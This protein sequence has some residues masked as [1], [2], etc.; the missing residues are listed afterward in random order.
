MARRVLLAAR[1]SGEAQRLQELLDHAGYEVEVTNSGRAAMKQARATPPDLLIAFPNLS[2]LSPGELFQTLRN[3]QNGRP[4]ALLAVTPAPDSSA[5]IQALSS[6]ADWFLQLPSTPDHI[7]SVVQEVVDNYEQNRQRLAGDR[8]QVMDT[9]L[10]TAQTLDQ[11]R[12][13]LDAARRELDEARRQISAQESLIE[14]R[15][16]ERTRNLE[17]IIQEL[18]GAQEQS[19]L[20]AREFRAL[21]DAEKQ[22][23]VD[24][25]QAVED[26]QLAQR[27]SLVYARDLHG[28]FEAER[29]RAEELRAA[30]VELEGSY[31]AT[32]EALST[33]LD[34][35]DKETEGHSRRVTAYTLAVARALGLMDEELVHV[36]RGAYLHDVGKIGIPDSIL[37]KPAKLT[38]EE[39]AVMKR[40]PEMGFQ[41]VGGIKFLT[42]AAPIVLHHHERF[43]GRGYPLGLTGDS[44]HIGARV[45]AIADTFDAITADRPYRKGTTPEAAR[46]EIVSCAGAQFDPNVVD[47]FLRVYAESD[48]FRTAG[49]TA[50]ITLRGLRAK[51]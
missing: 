33:A 29:K 10:S 42:L 4:F 38:D 43:D 40:H 32:I 25:K 15:A 31:D 35:R 12:K 13:E 44:I 16:A 8:R 37:H 6:G 7:L 47:A 46:G 1:R 21:L 36:E 50:E 51:G 2:D 48:I 14:Q 30:L 5:V 18:Q 23:S 39:W 20:Y 19:L 49:A 41:M 28:A 24:L 45:F 3:G 22:R 9:L 34:S 26:L 27:Q 11:S 17:A